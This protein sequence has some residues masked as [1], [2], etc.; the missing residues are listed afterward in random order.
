M[1]GLALSK[2]GL[3][4][5]QPCEMTAVKVPAIAARRAIS[6]VLGLD[7]SDLHAGRG[8]LARSIEAREA[9]TDHR[10]LEIT[11]DGPDHGLG[12]WNRSIMPVRSEFHCGISC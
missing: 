8:E 6:D 11:R 7:E 5:A 12:K 2:A 9:C 4:G 1:M 3:G 10:H